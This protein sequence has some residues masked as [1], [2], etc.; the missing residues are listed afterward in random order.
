MGW[1]GTLL[2]RIDG[3]CGKHVIPEVIS[4]VRARYFHKFAM[5]AADK[6]HTE[7]MAH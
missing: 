7:V 2:R 6:G 3:I 1:L 5:E 4:L